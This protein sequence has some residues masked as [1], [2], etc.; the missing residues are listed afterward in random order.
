MKAPKRVPWSSH[1]ELEELYEML[2][3]PSADLTTRR[4]GL[5][6]M[7]V[8]ISSPSCPSFIHLLHSLV[9][10]E[11]LPYPPASAEEAQRLRM[12]LG[13]AIVRFVNGLVDPL[14]TG[15]Y[16]RPISH[17][18][19]SLALPPSLIALR[20]RAT[21]EDLPPLPLLHSA[22]GQCISYLHHYSF[23]PLLASGSSAPPPGYLERLEASKRRVEGLIKRWKR[24]MKLRLREKE[25]REEDATAK[26]MR[27]VRKELQSHDARAL[28]AVLVAE[29]GLVP[30][31]PKKRA[32][33][34]QNL[35][36]VP[37]LKIWQPLLDHLCMTSHPD[38]SSELS[39]AILDIL[40]NPAD[41]PST[42]GFGGVEAAVKSDAEHLADRE[43]FR[44]GLAVWLV[45]L[46]SHGGA[47]IAAEDKQGWMRRILGGM[48]F[49]HD[50]VVV[51]RLHTALV[52]VDPRLT[53]SAELVDL[54]PPA[55]GGDEDEGL[56][57]LELG[58][59]EM[60]EQ[61]ANMAQMEERLATFE[62]MI[63]TRTSRAVHA[64][65]QD[66]ASSRPMTDGS[67]A[68]LPGW[69]RLTPEEWLPCPIGCVGTA[70]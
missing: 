16:A 70:R 65:P 69:H 48:L 15:L 11:I 49:L 13:M 43:S 28:V 38:L 29:G 25:V 21:H 30:I 6:R 26:E 35:P 22:L 62:R 17:L 58:D 42:S 46:W 1:A 23:L 34:R 39:A 24:V 2:F 36:P 9:A 3:A 59:V 32:L 33:P 53:S 57:G 54:L 61:S 51:R 27:Q 44:W 12:M 18:A 4:R 5:A 7:S 20:H 50:D 68:D 37:S 14:Q 31:A 63:S 66:T 67:T 47:G 40:L 10:I 55:E 64:L 56:Q 45:H 60:E 19:A 8:Y 52:D 41:G